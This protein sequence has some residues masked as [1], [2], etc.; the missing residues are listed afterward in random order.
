MNIGGPFN[1]VK[2]EE[3]EEDEDDVEAEEC[4]YV[5]FPEDYDFKKEYSRC[6]KEKLTSTES[7]L[8]EPL[9]QGAFLTLGVTVLL[10]AALSMRHKLSAEALGDFITFINFLLPTGSIFPRTLYL[11]KKFFHDWR[12]S[13]KIHCYCNY[14]LIYL[15]KDHKNCPNTFCNKDLCVSSAKAFFIEIPIVEQLKTLFARPGFYSDLNYRFKRK[16]A[17]GAI[18]GIYDGDLYRSKWDVLSNQD[19]ISLTMN[20]DGV[21]IFKSSKVSIWPLYF[22]INELPYKKRASIN[23][24]I[25]AGL[26]FGPS[27]GSM[28]TFLKPYHKSLLDI[29]NKGCEMTSPDRGTFCC[30]VLLLVCACDLPAKCTVMNFVQYN[31]L[32]GCAKCLQQGMTVKTD[33]HGSVHASEFQRNNP[34][35]PARTHEETFATATQAVDENKML[36]GIKGPSWLF[37]LPSYDFIR[38]MEIDYMHGACLGVMKLLMRFWFHG[39]HS[40]EAYSISHRLED[41]NRR[42]KS[43][44]PPFELSRISRSMEHFMTWKASEYRSL[45]MVYGLPL[46][47]TAWNFT[48]C[49]LHTFCFIC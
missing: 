13:L 48:C 27:K 8:N 24:M 44:K 33:V 12:P 10:L 7:K 49:I 15:E 29:A 4:S 19:N 14:Y 1:K 46:L 47:I 38:G 17:N 41:I 32:Y 25:L 16:K 45:L 20:T 9:F 6:P 36:L 39:E 2:V 35:G 11:F 22:I 5:H 34:D 18:E 40:N 43:F 3:K 23:N 26:W 42:M 28:L 21:P 37:G 31:G 30:R